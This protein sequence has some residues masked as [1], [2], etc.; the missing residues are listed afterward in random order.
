MHN[1]RPYHSKSAVALVVVSLFAACGGGGGEPTTEPPPVAASRRIEALT[2]TQQADG[3][4]YYTG[5]YQGARLN[6][7]H[8]G[9]VGQGAWTFYNGSGADRARVSIGDTTGLQAILNVETGYRTTVHAVNTERVEYRLYDPQGRFVVG[10]VLYAAGDQWYQGLMP[11]EAFA[12][13]DSLVSLS[14]VTAAI[15][16]GVTELET[17]IAQAG[18]A[19]R[20]APGP[21]FPWLS[22]AHAQGVDLGRAAFFGVTWDQFKTASVVGIT[23]IVGI[24]TATLGVAETAALVTAAAAVALPLT[25]AV[26]AGVVIGSWAYD[27][28]EQLSL[29]TVPTTP[30]DETDYQAASRPTAY[31]TEPDPAPPEP[32][33][34]A[35]ALPTVAP[36][37]NGFV[38]PLPEPAPVPPP[39]PV[40]PAPAP[41]PVPPPPGPATTCV[42][43]AIGIWYDK[44][45]YYLNARGQE[46]VHGLYERLVFESNQLIFSAT[47]A[48]GVLEGP[49]R[50]YDFDAQVDGP[51]R[52]VYRL[53]TEG[54]Y[55]ADQPIG[56]W[57]FYRTS[58]FNVG[59]ASLGKLEAEVTYGVLFEGSTV[60]AV[61][62]RYCPHAEPHAHP[63]KWGA[64]YAV[65]TIDLATGEQ[66]T[67][68]V[69][70][71]GCRQEPG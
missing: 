41:V 42:A 53:E 62:K 4:L 61:E 66:R 64:L 68:N 49:Y 28:R 67:Q 63:S 46:V 58:S 38:A 48:D 17:L 43:R 35:A 23:T 10:A 7:W 39:E 18:P 11:A 45:C 40:P 13:Y 25:T 55:R 60:V 8:T 47:Y 24:A 34:A 69:F 29:R 50:R 26:V 56:T 57:P 37:P 52:D 30:V 15:Q 59:V 1:P 22:T 16:R 32:L 51:A 21:G 36:V 14:N 31:S 2:A 44:Y 54:I 9:P 6:F 12:G 5:T 20:A 19:G 33:P 27:Q 3:A 65:Y 70:K 71:N